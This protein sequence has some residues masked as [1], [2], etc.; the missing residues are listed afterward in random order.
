MLVSEYVETFVS[1]LAAS[2]AIEPSTRD[3]YAYAARHI[4]A[5]LGDVR[6][7]DLSARS[8]RAWEA[9]LLASGLSTAS[10]R[11]AH[12][13]LRQALSDAVDE[14]ELESN[15]VS[16]VKPPKNVPIRPGHN[17]LDGGARRSLVDALS[18]E[19]PSVVRVAAFIALYTGLRAG[20]V[21]GLRWG[22]VEGARLWVRRS[23]GRDG[24]SVYLKASKTDRVRDVAV[25]SGLAEELGRW[26]AVRGEPPAGHYVL[27][28]SEPQRPDSVGKMWAKLAKRLGVVGSEGRRCTFHDL[29][30]TWA[31]MAVAAGVDVKTVASNLGHANAAMTLN[32]YASADPDAKRRC[33]EVID[34]L[35]G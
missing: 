20:E 11:K 6:V 22:D 34:A 28:G 4:S 5:G 10:V 24:G 1:Y 27:G 18:R 35:L 32:V 33:A 2:G 23:V 7:E 26:R 25:P 14:G 9:S 13:L 8:V 21:C 12:R 17:V 3:R 19:E 16:R 15:P 31:T 29:R 30:H